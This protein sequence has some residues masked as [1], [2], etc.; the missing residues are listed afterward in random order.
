M[1]L[2]WQLVDSAFP[3]GT[4]AHSWGLEAAWQQGAVEDSAALLRFV[5]AAAHVTA[6]GMVPLMNEAYACPERWGS[7]DELAQAALTNG[8]ANRA[9]RQQGRTLLATMARVWP[10][11]RAEDIRQ[12]GAALWAHVGPASGVVFRHLLVPAGTARRL[13]LYSA[14][15]GI[16]AAAVRLGIVGAYEAQRMQYDASGTLENLAR[17]AEPLMAEDLAQTE[18]IPD[19][20]QMQ[21]DRLYSR[22]FQ[23]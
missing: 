1:F 15:R 19:L 2:V 8:I 21:H 18:P 17:R 20:L 22:L 13:L 4:F 9:S 5:E 7:L 12:Q 3:T 6:F 16:L 10:S 11:P 23:S 14:A